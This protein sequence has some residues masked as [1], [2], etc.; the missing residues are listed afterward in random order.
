MWFQDLFNYDFRRTEM[1]IIPYATQQGEISFCAYNTGVGWRKIIENMHKNATVAQWYKEHGKHDVFAKGKNVN[2]ASYEHSLRIDA[3]DASRVR[4]LEHDIPLTAA[5]EDR[6][7]RKRAFEEAAKVRRIYEEL[8]LKKSTEPVVQI[9]SMQQILSA[10][11]GVTVKPVQ[12]APANG[13][14]GAKVERPETEAA[15]AGD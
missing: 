13:N 4:H 1:C 2:L 10:V 5:E 12:I 11:P 3:E 9:G 15:V 7:R 14:G 8:V 6:I